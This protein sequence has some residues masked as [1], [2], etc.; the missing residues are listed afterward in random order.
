MR[1][2]IRLSIRSKLMWLL[3]GL[4]VAM[5]MCVAAWNSNG[6]TVL[7]ANLTGESISDVH[8]QFGT[9]EQRCIELGAH[10]EK[11]FKIDPDDEAKM[12]LSYIAGDGH[13]RA[14]INVYLTPE[15]HG[16]IK[17]EVLPNGIVRTT[18]RTLMF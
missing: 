3:I 4:F 13:H 10:K 18:E 12:S 7:V 11:S 5:S 8:L 15:F 17:L 6:N 9:R 2:N 1:L 14:L 16:L